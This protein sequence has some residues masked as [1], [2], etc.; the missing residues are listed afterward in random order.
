VRVRATLDARR[1]VFFDEMG[2]NISLAP[3]YA[4]SPKGHRAYT[5]VL[6][7][8]GKNTTLLSSISLDGIGPSLAVEG[9]TDGS[10]E[11]LR[12]GPVRPCLK[13]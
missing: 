2:L 10:Y 12:P 3:H 6:R 8:R 9:A 5:R 13:R 11:K 4:Y 7:S 1:L